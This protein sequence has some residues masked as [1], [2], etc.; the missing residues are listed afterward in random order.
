[1]VSWLVF[2]FY[3]FKEDSTTPDRRRTERDNKRQH[4]TKRHKAHSA[5][6]LLPLPG[7]LSRR[8]LASSSS[9]ALC[10]SPAA[11][12]RATCSARSL[13]FTSSTCQGPAFLGGIR[14]GE[15]EG[16]GLRSTEAGMKS[17]TAKE[18]NEVFKSW[19]GSFMRHTVFVRGEVRFVSYFLKLQPSGSKIRSNTILLECHT[20][21][22]VVIYFRANFGH[23][24]LFVWPIQNY[25]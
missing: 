21:V 8:S 6:L 13:N 4:K 20:K 17:T 14:N 11:L 9:I 5:Q 15:G 1:M 24:L 2:S 10:L 16:G 23:D 3:F 12:S 25:A 18:K 22:I 19:K 7:V